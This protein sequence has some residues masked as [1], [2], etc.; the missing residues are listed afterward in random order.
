[1]IKFNGIA[2]GISYCFNVNWSPGGSRYL[3]VSSYGTH[4]Q[5]VVDEIWSESIDYLNEEK[6]KGEEVKCISDRSVDEDISQNIR[7]QHHKENDRN[8]MDLKKNW[9][10]MMMKTYRN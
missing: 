7:V 8:G 1:M 9:L 5:K 6:R 2:Q 4:F 10:T 3:G